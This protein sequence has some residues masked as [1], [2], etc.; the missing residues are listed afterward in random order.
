M[1]I[2]LVKVVFM[3]FYQWSTAGCVLFALFETIILLIITSHF[4]ALLTNPGALE[5]N[6]VRTANA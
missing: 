2:A 4:R 1:N 3:D 6:T 5:R